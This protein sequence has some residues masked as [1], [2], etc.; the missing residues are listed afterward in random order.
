MDDFRGITS[1]IEELREGLRT[2]Y[3]DYKAGLL[4]KYA[5]EEA[6]RLGLDWMTRQDI[7]KF[8]LG[9]ARGGVDKPRDPQRLIP[10]WNVLFSGRYPLP[11]AKSD[12]SGLLDI[13]G[14]H[15]FYH[16]SLKFFHVHQHRNLRA[17]KD[18]LGRFAFYHF[19]EYFHKFPPLPRAV[20]IGQWDIELKHGVYC[21]TEKQNYDGKIGRSAARDT[22]SGYFLPKGPNICFIL[23]QAKKETPKY[24]ML[25]AE[26]DDADTFETRIMSGLMLKGSEGHKYFHSPVYAERVPSNRS[27]A[28]NIKRCEDIPPHVMEELE[29][30]ANT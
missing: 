14:P 8:R 15:G 19:S 23:R 28:C 12:D 22:Y 26:Q 4:E 16:A 27:V 21:V 6:D 24:Y 9:A 13:Q 1:Q 7:D 11:T 2:L 25:A 3:P 17:K 30:L 18:L 10:L 29:A 20:L 5:K